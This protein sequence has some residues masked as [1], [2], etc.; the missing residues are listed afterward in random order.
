MKKARIDPYFLQF[1]RA[2]P[3][4]YFK[5]P[6]HIYTPA[7]THCDHLEGGRRAFHKLQFGDPCGVCT[8]CL[9]DNTRR[10]RICQRTQAE[11]L[12]ERFAQIVLVYE[13]S[14]GLLDTKLT[15]P[16][17]FF[18]L[19]CAKLMMSVD[20]VYPQ[21]VFPSTTTKALYKVCALNGKDFPPAWA[22]GQKRFRESCV[23]D[24]ED[25]GKKNNL[26]NPWLEA[27]R[28]RKDTRYKV[29]DHNDGDALTITID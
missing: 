20:S 22:I 10:C 19:S 21:G 27:K 28:S 25:Q 5:I 24:T 18:C 1:G 12:P 7:F 15:R 9:R 13:V 23:C 16:H 2:L 17:Q 8:P 26:W 6:E 14:H 4:R 3:K 29:M 11:T